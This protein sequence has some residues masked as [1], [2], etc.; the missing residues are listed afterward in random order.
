MSDRAGAPPEETDVFISGEDGYHTYRIP[1]IV[2]S[3]N[4]DVLA[5]CEARKHGSGDSGDIDL[6]MKRSTDGGKTWS[7]MRI[8]ADHGPHTIGNPC[9]VI[10]GTTGTIWMPLTRNRGD[11]WEGQILGG[12]TRE[13]RTVW[14]TKSN[15]DGRTWT[16]PVDISETVRQPHW[17]WYATG[18]GVGIQIQ[19]GPHKGRLLIPCDHSDHDFGGHP[20]RSHAI[21][22]DDGGKTW[23]CGEPIGERTNE[24]QAVEL[25][26]GTVLMNMRSYHDKKRRALA[27]SSD[28]GETWSE[29]TLDPTLVEPVCQASILRYTAQPEYAKNRVLFCNPAGDARDEMTVRL[30]YDECRTWPVAKTLYV[31][32]AAYSCLVVLPDTSIG[33]LYERDDYGKIVLARF[34]LELLTDGKDRLEKQGA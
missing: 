8:I 24:C 21:L 11:E 28:G 31:G 7:R 13:A 3:P 6:A 33:C 27:T 29:V 18:P 30:S 14:L 4:G 25:T 9:P 23:R 17:R 19:R 5:F 15:D 20:Y 2:V 26:D 10:D 16:E 12:A 32:S 22:S 1:A 34:T